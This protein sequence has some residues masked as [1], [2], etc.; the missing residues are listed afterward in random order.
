MTQ[1]RINLLP[2]ELKA[3]FAHL[4]EEVK[5]GSSLSG[6]GEVL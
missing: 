4:L 6:A 2:D 1:I 3:L 5:G